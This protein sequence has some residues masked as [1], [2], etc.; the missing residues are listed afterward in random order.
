MYVSRGIDAPIHCLWRLRLSKSQM[1]QLRAMQNA[2][3]MLDRSWPSHTVPE[4]HSL[5]CRMTNHTPQPS[6]K[7]EAALHDSSLLRVL[8]G[9]HLAHV[10]GRQ[11]ADQLVAVRFR[12]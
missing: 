11:R 1:T 5:K 12:F 7:L 3:A 9:V 8:L 4:S 2:D 10:L 6:F